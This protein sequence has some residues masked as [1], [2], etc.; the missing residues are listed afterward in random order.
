MR[1]DRLATGRSIEH[2]GSPSRR[3]L[4]EALSWALECMAAKAVRL[5]RI[6]V[7]KSIAQV[8]RFEGLN[9]IETAL[10]DASSA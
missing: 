3:R 4:N 2:T 7:T 1:T 10:G 9:W 5:V 6:W 8:F